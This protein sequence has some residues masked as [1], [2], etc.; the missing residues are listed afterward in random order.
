[1]R[2]FSNTSFAYCCN[3]NL[4]PPK[5]G[6]VEL[7]VHSGGSRAG[8]SPVVSSG[9]ASQHP[10]MWNS[11]SLQAA[12]HMGQENTRM[13]K[14]DCVFYVRCTASDLQCPILVK[15]NGFRPFRIQRKRSPT[16]GPMPHHL[17]CILQRI[18]SKLLETLDDEQHEIQSTM[19]TEKPTIVDSADIV[20]SYCA[21]TWLQ[22]TVHNIWRVDETKIRTVR[23]LPKIAQLPP[24]SPMSLVLPDSWSSSHL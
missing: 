8:C 19:Q 11:H 14:N 9:L 7:S 12:D 3:M 13:L 17:L 20:Y 24:L 15:V 16:E 1:M 4:K 21:L 18:W 6:V 5:V 23:V 2:K 10:H 22:I